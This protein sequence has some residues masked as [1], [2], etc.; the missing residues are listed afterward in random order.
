MTAQ[1]PDRVLPAAVLWDMDGTLIDTEPIWQQSQVEL[2]AR[3]GAEWTHEDGLSLVGSGLE[4][5]GEILRDKGVDMEVEEIVQWMT[6]YVTERL[7]G[8]EL[9]WR[10]G[11]RELVEELHDRGV[12]TAL[13]TMSRRKMALVAAEALGARGFRVVVAGDDVDRPKPFPDAYLAAA[14][15]LGVEATACVAVEDSATGVAAAVASG[16]VT[17]AVEH[18]VPLSEIGGGDVHLT[19]LAGVDVDRLVELTG[20]ALAARTEAVAR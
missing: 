13:V 14:D 18:I 12:P 2:T 8:E 5:S 4:R 6:D 9:P 15:A 7:D 17:V 19:T 1:H 16:A 20:P 11:A 3:Y 10:P